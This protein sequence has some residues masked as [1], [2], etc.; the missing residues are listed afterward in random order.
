MASVGSFIEGMHLATADIKTD[1]EPAIVNLVE[2]VRE[3]LSKSIKLEEK[4][5]NLKDNQSMGAI[6][7]PIRWFQ[8]K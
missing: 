5:G 8:A 1:G 2:E 4:R 3:R 6:E 7:A